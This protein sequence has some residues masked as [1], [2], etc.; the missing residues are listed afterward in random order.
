MGAGGEEDFLVFLFPRHFFIMLKKEARKIYREKRMK[1]SEAERSKLDDLLLIQFQSV[2][3]PFLEVLLSYWPIEENNEPD[4]HLFTEFLKFRNPELKVCYPVSDFQKISLQ[5]VATDIDT[6]FEKRNLDIY[7]PDK[8]D[9]VPA[10]AIDMVFVP[11]LAFDRDGYRT[12]YGKGFYDRY[13]AGC[14]KDCL[15]VGFSYFEPFDLMDDRNEFDVPLSLC[16]TPQ[17]IYVFQLL[18]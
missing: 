8:G 15:R 2:D 4:T 6:P 5:A 9:P 17:N 13:L 3:L 7:E 12:G 10:G 16:I 14:R 11:L 18:S 1:L